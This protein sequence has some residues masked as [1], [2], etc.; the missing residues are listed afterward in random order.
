MTSLKTILDEH[1]Y[2]PYTDA[3]VD[4][5][6]TAVTEYL[7]SKYGTVRS[8]DIE[9]HFDY[10]TRNLIISSRSERVKDMLEKELSP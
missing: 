1:L 8:S 5:L 10:A 7:S 4:N 3:T 6:I 2:E 9:A